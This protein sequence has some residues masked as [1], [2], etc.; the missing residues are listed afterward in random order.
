MTKHS[1]KERDEKHP[2]YIKN[3]HVPFII[4]DFF[5]FASKK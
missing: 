3:V 2:A 1:I 4:S 5:I